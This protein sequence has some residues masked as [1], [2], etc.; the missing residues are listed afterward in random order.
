M[1]AWLAGPGVA[2]AQGRLE[3]TPTTQQSLLYLQEQWIQWIAAFEQGDSQ[4]TGEILSDLLATADPLGM[5]ALPD[6][7]VA[8]LV[9]AVEAARQGDFQDA[10]LA[11]AAAERLDPGR[12]E[13]AFARATV[14]RLAGRWPQGVA[15]WFGGYLRILQQPMERGVW[16]ADLAV[17]ALYVLLLA[18][19]LFVALGMAVHG[20]FLVADVGAM[21]ARS[22]SRDHL[23]PAI[24]L[25]LALLF[26][27][28]PLVLPAGVGWL[29]LWWSLLLWSR[30]S[31][32]ERVVLALLWLVVGLTPLAVAQF[33]EQVEV[34]L[35]PPVQ[36]LDRLVQGRLYGGMFSDL[37][38]LEKLL[39]GEPAVDHLL[40]DV[41]RR[42][43]Q[44][45]RARRLYE[46]V[47]EAEPDNWT[48]L[49]DLG[50]Y[51]FYKNDQGAARQRFEEATKAAPEEALPYFNLSRA[52]HVAY[53]FEEGNAQLGRAQELAGSEV[54]RWMS[55]T[56]EG[57]VLY[58][59]GGLARAPI[60]RRWLRE[61]LV[62][63][64]EEGVRA[65]TLLRQGWSLLVALGVALGALA[66]HALRVRSGA[67]PLAPTP[68]PG[69]NARLLVPGLAAVREGRGGAA[70]GALLVVALLVVVG[71]DARLGFDV[72]L[73]FAH[74]GA[75][76]ALAVAG[77]AL[78]FTLRA[79]VVLRRAGG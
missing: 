59:N 12:P 8:A 60:L 66:F 68:S 55:E 45:E 42:M 6:L 7:A 63:E 1:L 61:T 77:L 18:G 2:S 48:A 3:L 17:E 25:P 56:G 37:A 71:L 58:A 72:P 54:S 50:S 47:L 32:S 34:H 44:W 15:S 41:H 67:S 40:A 52:Y 13:T 79:F 64:G 78:F 39:P 73:R 69:R 35:S 10:R 19:A 57:S 30:G 38:L 76:P 5:D 62:D 4:R 14:E 70:A 23:P 46:R 51:Y 36:A 27:L 49:S 28:W 29:V 26:L 74:G 9:E 20:R 24:T 21:I 75:D 33:R 53:L 16:S 22:T 43:G 65:M 11:L 31:T